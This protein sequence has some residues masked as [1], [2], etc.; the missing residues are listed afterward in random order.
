MMKRGLWM[1]VGIVLAV[2]IG[3]CTGTGQTNRGAVASPGDPVIG[4]LNKG[5]AQLTVNINSVS[6]RISGLQ[7]SSATPD[8]TLQE[9]QALDLSGWQLHRQQWVLQ[10]DHLMVAR[11]LLQR[12]Q[13]APSEKI[14]LLDQWREH[15][16]TYL[17]SF[18]ELRQKRHILE[19]QH[20]EM[21]ARLIERRLE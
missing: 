4:L 10:R 18:D 6:K 9:L 21:E 13:A 2:G 15:W 7:Q 12:V 3:A 19:S 8:P 14:R 16:N 11:D 20:R 1:T 17:K 5:I